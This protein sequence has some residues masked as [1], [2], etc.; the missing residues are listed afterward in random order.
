M[1]NCIVGQSGGPTAVIN[2]S[3]CGVATAAL[4]SD[5]I[6]KVFGACNGI[7]GVLAERFLDMAEILKTEVQK[8]LCVGIVGLMTI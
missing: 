3:L 7:E 1:K 5:K 6:D 8:R 4:K 2:S